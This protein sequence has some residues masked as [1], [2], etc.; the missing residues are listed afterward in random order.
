MMTLW[1]CLKCNSQLFPF[2]TLDNKKFMQHILNS[3]N[4]KNDKKIEFNNL[5]LK[6]PPSLSSLFNQ[7]NTI[8]Q[9]NDHKDP[10]NVVKCKYYDLEEVQSMK[11][12]NKNSC[13]SLFHINTYSL[14]VVST[15]FLL[16]CFVCLKESTCEIRK[17]VFYFTSKALFILE[18]SKYHDIIKC[19]IMEHETHII[20]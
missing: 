20:E 19:P 14:K 3:S 17:N 2:G 8:P 9:T 11:I 7:F 18:I 6:P 10:E 12:P 16:V 5:V 1:S 13:L 4:M 15:T